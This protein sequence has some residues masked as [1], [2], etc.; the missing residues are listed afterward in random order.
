MSAALQA[1]PPDVIAEVKQRDL[2]TIIGQTVHLHREGR[3]FAGCCPFHQERTGSFFVYPNDQHYHCFGCGAHGDAVEFVMNAHR[4][5]FRE[6]VAWLSGLDIGSFTPAERPPQHSDSN[7]NAELA[8]KIWSEACLPEGTLVQDYLRSRRLEL[9]DERVIRFHP[10]CPNGRDKMPAMVALMSDP[11]TGKPRGI[12]R[13]FLRPDG[14]G[15]V[16]KMMLGPAGVIR[17]CER[18]TNGLGIAEGIE[19][20]LAVSQRVGWGPVWAAGSAGGIRSFP[21]LPMT[22]LHIFC[23]HDESGVGLKAARACGQRWADAAR[24]A[25]NRDRI[26]IECYVHI[27]PEGKD[28]D[29]ATLG[30]DV[31]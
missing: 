26:V 11:E 18:I 14:S 4:L 22:T 12:H 1:I 23:D 6:A 19:T 10:E 15:K 30:E 21:V 25:W 16:S 7:R 17:L 27:P 8:R 3:L 5:A 9:P 20:S 31:P 13:T 24:I 2:A 28:W 29:E